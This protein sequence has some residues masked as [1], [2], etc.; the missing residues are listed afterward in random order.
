MATV[1]IQ[2]NTVDAVDFSNVDGR[3]ALVRAVNLLT[4]AAS[5]TGPRCSSAVLSVTPNSELLVRTPVTPLIMPT[6]GTNVSISTTSGDKS[7]TSAGGGN[8]TTLLLR[9]AIDADA[10]TAHTV[11]QFYRLTTR[12]AT[13]TTDTLNVG[14]V[15]TLFGVNIT[16]TNNNIAVTPNSFPQ[17]EGVTGLMTSINRNPALRDRFV[18]VSSGGVFDA[19]LLVWIGGPDSECPKFQYSFKS[20]NEDTP[21]I[22][23]GWSDNVDICTTLAAAS[24]GLLSALVSKVPQYLSTKPNFSSTGFVEYLDRHTFMNF[25]VNNTSPQFSQIIKVNL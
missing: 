18:G 12:V 4:G 24:N 6:A 5:G 1:N 7:Q 15:I 21:F 14:A 16:C 25:G 17:S 11:S 2:L 8:N 13:F 20:L 3:N 10:G 9:N 19:C 22:V 23:V